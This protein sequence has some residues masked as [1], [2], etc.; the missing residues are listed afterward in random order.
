MPIIND[1]WTGHLT[2]L[3]IMKHENVAYRCTSCKA[4]NLQ[5]LKISVMYKENV[6]QHAFHCLC[7]SD[8]FHINENYKNM[9]NSKCLVLYN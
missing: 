5:T 3:I 4:I 6:F 2:S 9:P 1:R 7:H 8:L